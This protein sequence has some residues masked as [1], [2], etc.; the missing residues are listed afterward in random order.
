MDVPVSY[1]LN[2]ISVSSLHRNPNLLRRHAVDPVLPASDLLR[3]LVVHR[4][5]A[6]RGE[7]LDIAASAA[8]GVLHFGFCGRWR[9]AE[10]DFAGVVSS[11]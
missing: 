10:A 9:D 3:R 1:K 6:P 5:K 7:S 2:C 11:E 4:I 8:A